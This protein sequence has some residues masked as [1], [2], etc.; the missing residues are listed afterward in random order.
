M[1]LSTPLAYFFCKQL[2]AW[3]VPADVH[4]YSCIL[5]HA[6]TITNGFIAGG[7]FTSHAKYCHS[8]L[9]RGGVDEL[10]AV[11][12][13]Y[14]IKESCWP[15]LWKWRVR[16]SWGRQELPCWLCWSCGRVSFFVFWALCACTWTWSCSSPVDE[17]VRCVVSGVCM[18]MKV[19]CGS[20]WSSDH[21]RLSVSIRLQAASSS[22]VFLT[23]RNSVPSEMAHHLTWRIISHDTSSHMT[24]HLTWRIISHDTS[25]H[26]THHLTWHIISHDASSHMTHHLTW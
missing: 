22:L 4:P 7:S 16:R 20:I 5:P 15:E 13:R 3:A 8:G 2:N 11:E 6:L 19:I 26:M 25:S 17:W 1:H 12:F 10:Q 18:Y 24:H 14:A 23:S 9:W 21:L